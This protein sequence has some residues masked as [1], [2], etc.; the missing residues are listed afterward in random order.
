MKREFQQK[1]DFY[2]QLAG[3]KPGAATAVIGGNE[4]EGH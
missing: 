2:F 1:P 4:L 3:F